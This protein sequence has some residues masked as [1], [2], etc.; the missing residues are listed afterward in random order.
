MKKSHL[1]VLRRSF[2]QYR[3]EI[4]VRNSLNI[5]PSYMPL[6]DSE[7]YRQ[8]KP[9]TWYSCGP[10]VY[11]SAHLG[12]ART[13]ISTDIIRRIITN[14]FKIPLNFAM[15]I[16]DIDDKIINK[17]KLLGYTETEQ[18]LSLA[19]SY[20]KDFF[21]D[22]A[23][24]NILPPDAVLR[25]SEHIPEIIN[26]IRRLIDKDHA[27]IRDDGVYFRISS[28]PKSKEYDQFGCVPTS[29]A[30]EGTVNEGNQD[31]QEGH[32]STKDNLRDFALWKIFPPSSSSSPPSS[33]STTSSHTVGW[34]SP[35]GHGRPGWHIEC[36]TMTYAYFGKYLDI[37]SGGIDLKFP[38]HSNEIVQSECHH[39]SCCPS[40]SQS[41]QSVECA[42]KEE[43]SQWVRIWL[44]TGHLH[45]VG[46]KMSKSLK[47]F[48]SI[49]E[50]LS[51]KLTS[52]PEDDFRIFCLQ[53]K[54]S[55][56]LTYSID[57]IYEASNYR[58]KLES[59]FSLAEHLIS[60]S[61]TA[62]LGKKMSKKPTKES[63][64]LM[65]H[66][67][68][69]QKEIEKA[70]MNDFDTDTALQQTSHLIGLTI[71]YVTLVN[72]PPHSLHPIEPVISISNYIRN[73]CSETF[74]LKSFSVSSLSSTASVTDS[75]DALNE[76]SKELIDLALNQRST[77][78][79]TILSH[80]KDLKKEMKDCTTSPSAK[81]AYEK[82]MQH[83]KILLSLTDETRNQ[84]R[85]QFKINVMDLPDGD[86]TW[87]KE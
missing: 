25:V 76:N 56:L 85:N 75:A 26:F 29:L 44:H 84:L 60:T 79:K 31:D 63:M 83:W 37:H 66:F 15:G 65:N 78:K 36:S 1:L 39:F 53:H 34:S 58:K 4:H 72:S 11:D 2:H 28:L 23:R 81:N 40:Q 64:E 30:E 27:Y 21:H 3:P 32:L 67:L 42:Q 52:C 71:P 8:Q 35:W 68:V 87:S 49:Q 14:Y 20:E 22:M 16:T 9:L 86:S 51:Q 61:S 41:N 18:F 45:I 13:Y 54:Y 43:R 47:N 46:R 5:T 69:V 50:Y 80:M 7:N 38:H 48:V 6:H 77:M 82:E 73:L 62:S 10:T 24:L 33:S 55:A 17:G 74:G 19:Y 57:R 59:F 12:H 70:F